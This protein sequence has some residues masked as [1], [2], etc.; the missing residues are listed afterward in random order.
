MNKKTLVF[1]VSLTYL[2]VALFWEL[3][4]ISDFELTSNRTYNILSLSMF[5][6]YFLPFVL[7]LY[8][9]KKEFRIFFIVLYA[10]LFI[11]FFPVVLLGTLFVHG[12]LD[13]GW[14]LVYEK[15][16]D[17]KSFLAVYRT[18]DLG[19]L[20]GDKLAA[21]IVTPIFSWLVQRTVYSLNLIEEYQA[22]RN[23]PIRI[24][25]KGKY[26]IIPSPD[27]LY[28]INTKNFSDSD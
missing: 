21:S 1:I 23:L 17:E 20:G 28:S 9:R 3:F 2:I 16:I 19:A 5:P 26:F 22:D 7:L 6:A 10:G 25:I 18:T 13:N 4:Q 14:R 8:I 12:D 15:P 27:D 24:D 11:F